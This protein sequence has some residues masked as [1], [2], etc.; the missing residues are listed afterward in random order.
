MCRKLL[1]P[2]MLDLQILNMVLLKS[3]HQT[4]EKQL[5]E[6]ARL[7][8]FLLLKPLVCPPNVLLHILLQNG[9][10]FFLQ[11]FFCLRSEP[12]RV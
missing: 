1:Q 11:F 9:F 5:L 3:E 6:V 10:L 2:S 12:A 4:P 7:F 8:I